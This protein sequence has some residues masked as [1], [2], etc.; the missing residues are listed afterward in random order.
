M[1]TFLTILFSLLLILAGVIWYVQFM[2]SQV[3]KGWKA[4]I[5]PV[6]EY[7]EVTVIAPDETE[8]G[9]YVGYHDSFH[10]RLGRKTPRLFESRSRNV[11][12]FLVKSNAPGTIKG[13]VY[14]CAKKHKE[15]EEL[16]SRKPETK[17]F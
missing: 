5:T 6:R 7:F 1:M 13:L 10:Q 11:Q 14:V 12:P 15:N 9:T 17:E 4:S 2:R 8:W 3:V 16:A